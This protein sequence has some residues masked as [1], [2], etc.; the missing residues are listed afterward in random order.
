MTANDLLIKN[1][2]II[3]PAGS[4]DEMSDILISDG[5]I[6]QTGLNLTARAT[7]TIDAAGLIACPGFIDLHCHL[8]Q[9]GHE[10]KETIA[11]G[12]SAACHGGFTSIC[13]MPNTNP[14]LD[15]AAV[16]HYV[17][18]VAAI[19]APNINILP[20]GCITRN[21]SGKELIDMAELCEAGCVG[22]SD[23]GSSVI[24]SRLML[25]AMQTCQSLGLPVIEHCEDAD[26]A[27]DGQMNEGW[28]SAR[29][30][31]AGIPAAAEES[32][33]SRDIAL[34]EMTGARLHLTHISTRGSVDLIRTAKKKGVP[35]TADV[36]PHHLTLTEE[37][38][39]GNRDGIGVSLTYDTNAKV[40]PPLRTAADIEALITAINDGTLDAI[41]T[42]HA[43]HP[44]EDKLCEFDLA[45]FG[46]SGFETAFGAL[47]TLVHSDKIKL[48][49]LLACLTSQPAKIINYTNGITGA[50]KQSGKADITLLDINRQWTVETENMLSLGKNTPY[51]GQQFKGLVAATIHNGVISY[52]DNS[53]RIS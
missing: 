30:G 39:I 18:S 41:A 36:T 26:L 43:P 8:R 45:A 33:V 27:A 35:V 46:I 51:A 52:K 6:K 3:D 42:D 15:N 40:N 50:I 24:N 10:H 17:K 29:L 4:V 9:P 38:V 7:K 28:V 16:I 25:L 37:R 11:T 34:C 31:L 48:H 14:P 5:L 21:R 32:I 44:S 47:M 49:T 22:F 12:A 23:D 13:C 20:V 19:D 1:V 53:I 2:R